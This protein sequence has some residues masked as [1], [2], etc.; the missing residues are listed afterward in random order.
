MTIETSIIM[1]VAQS[2]CGAAAREGE[3]LSHTHTH[4]HFLHTN[5]LMLSLFLPPAS[6]FFV[7]SSAT[8]STCVWIRCQLSIQSSCFGCCVSL[9]CLMLL[10]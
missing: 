10:L 2:G 5:T 3:A 9:C 7:G 8:L 1:K 6:H 4:V